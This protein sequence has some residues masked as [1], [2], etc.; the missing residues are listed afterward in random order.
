[1]DEIKIWRTTLKKSD[2]EAQ[3]C[4]KWLGKTEEHFTDS[5]IECVP[6]HTLHDS[7]FSLT[8]LI[9]VRYCQQ[10]ESSNDSLKWCRKIG[11]I[12]IPGEISTMAYVEPHQRDTSFAWKGVDVKKWER[13]L[14]TTDHRIL[15]CKIITVTIAVLSCVSNTTYDRSSK[16][17][18]FQSS[19]SHSSQFWTTCWISGSRKKTI[20]VMWTTTLLMTPINFVPHTLSTV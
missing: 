5:L 16:W 11:F 14:N 13:I 15:F 7:S 12:L 2:L 19:F 10:F 4:T 6:R 1:M 3:N 9:C 8:Q 18:I 20:S 17:G